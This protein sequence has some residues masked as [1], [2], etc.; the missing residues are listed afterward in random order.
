MMALRQ[1]SGV[2]VRARVSVRVCVRV[3]VCM[4][5]SFGDRLMRTHADVWTY[6][7]YAAPDGIYFGKLLQA[8]EPSVPTTL[9]A[10]RC[11]RHCVASFIYKASRAAS[12]R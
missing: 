12:A 2:C 11:E 3:C 4:R 8:R 5:P 9:R 6:N 7:L 1:R 10:A